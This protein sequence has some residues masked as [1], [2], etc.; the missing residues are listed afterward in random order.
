MNPCTILNILS[1]VCL[2]VHLSVCPSVC[3]SIHLSVCPSV[4]L[5][6]CPSVCPFIC[7]SVRLSIKPSVFLPVHLFKCLSE[8]VLELS[9]LGFENSEKLG[10]D[11]HIFI[12]KRSELEL[13]GYV[14]IAFIRAQIFIGKKVLSSISTFLPLSF[15]YPSY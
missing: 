4:H 13:E 14:S 10:Y 1:S 7:R 6:V 8:C 2:S 5:S 11:R 3:L 12:S 15:L 9:K